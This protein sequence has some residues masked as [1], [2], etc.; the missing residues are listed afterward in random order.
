MHLFNCWHHFK[1]ILKVLLNIYYIFLD[2]LMVFMDFCCQSSKVV[3]IYMIV[4][5]CLVIKDTQSLKTRH[6]LLLLPSSAP[7]WAGFTFSEC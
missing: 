5:F 7:L 3:L 2:K 6:L 1:I 4:R